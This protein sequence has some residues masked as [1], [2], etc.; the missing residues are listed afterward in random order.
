[1]IEMFI[2]TDENILILTKCL[3]DTEQI[4]HDGN[5]NWKN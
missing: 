2:E 1:M 3:L 5:V 4:L